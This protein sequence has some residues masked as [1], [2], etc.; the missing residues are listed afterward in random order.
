MF[1]PLRG[2]NSGSLRTPVMVFLAVTGFFMPVS[3]TGTISPAPRPEGDAAWVL[4]FAD[5]PAAL[6]GR[7]LEL[8]A[9][10]AGAAPRTVR[11]PERAGVSHGTAPSAGG[12]PAPVLRPV[13]ADG[14]RSTS[15]PC[16]TERR[17]VTGRLAS[18][19][20]APPVLRTP[21]T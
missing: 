2:R 17:A 11:L 9:S 14:G 20:T 4:D 7:S 5:A 3:R 13:Q 21:G 15:G 16:S 12:R 1:T 6:P 19:A 10:S 8:P 18:P